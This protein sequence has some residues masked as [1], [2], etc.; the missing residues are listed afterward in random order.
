MNELQVD[1]NNGTYFYLWAANRWLNLRTDIISAVLVFGAGALVLY[2]GVGSGLAAMTIHYAFDLAKFLST[3]VR[4]YAEMEMNMN[5]VERVLEYTKIEQEPPAIV[6]HN[7][8]PNNWP[9]RGVVQVRDLSIRYSKELPDVLRNVSFDI[10]S[11]EKVAIVGRT[12]AGKSTLSLAFFRILPLSSGSITI[13]G[14]DISTIGLHDLRSKLNIIPQ[15]P[16]LFRGT[17]RNNLDPLD[18]HT[19]EELWDSLNRV[20]L[21]SSFQTSKENEGEAIII[22]LEYPVTE[23]GGNFS[24]GQ[25]QLIC[26]ARALLRKTKLIILD[27]ATASV[28]HETDIRIQTVIR[29]EF[30]RG[31]VITIAH[32]LRTIIDYDK[33]LVLDQGKVAEYGSPLQL[34]QQS[35][36][37]IFK[38]MCEETGE[39]DELIELAKKGFGNIS[40]EC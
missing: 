30:A 4:Y 35:P 24:Q 2:S 12:G 26:L 5:S 27:E 6:E 7:R 9:D 14:V 1:S 19:D 16:V 8:P 21:F 40:P 15:D 33:I 22:T 18:E 11:H 36:A 28:D 34:I 23:N 39:L 29:Q 17:L 31:T 20:N 13:D 38:S 10:Q 32:R 25:R 37:G 3:N